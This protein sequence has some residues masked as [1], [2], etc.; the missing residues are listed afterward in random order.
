MGWYSILDE[1]QLAVKKLEGIIGQVKKEF[2]A[3]VSIIGSI[4]YLTPLKDFVQKELI[5]IQF[6][7]IC[8]IKK[9]ISRRKKLN[10]I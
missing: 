4:Y 9:W 2:R 7:C 8:P 5:G 10:F 1:T 3:K 6:M